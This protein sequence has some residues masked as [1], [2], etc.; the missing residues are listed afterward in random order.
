MTLLRITLDQV[1]NFPM[2]LDVTL[3][4]LVFEIALDIGQTSVSCL[5]FID[6]LTNII[7]SV[8]YV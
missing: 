6:Y 8:L 7:Y 4:F 1:S 5:I 3:H 2:V